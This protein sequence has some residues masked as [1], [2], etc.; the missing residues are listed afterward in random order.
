[1]KPLHFS[2]P[3]ATRLA[4]NKAVQIGAA[5]AVDWLARV[6]T[7]EVAAIR[8]VAEVFGIIMDAPYTVAN[9]VRFCQFED[10]PNSKMS[11]AYLEHHRNRRLSFFLHSRPVAAVYED[12]SVSRSK[13]YPGPLV[14]IDHAI[15]AHAF[16]DEHAAP[17]RGYLWAEF[18]DPALEDADAALMSASFSRYDGPDSPTPPTWKMSVEKMPKVDAVLRLNPAF[19]ARLDIAGSRLILARNRLSLIN[20]AIEGSICLESLLTDEENAEISYRLSLR[21]A[22]LIGTDSTERLEIWNKLKKFY[23]LRSKGVHGSHKSKPD[24]SKTVDDGLSICM[25]VLQKLVELGKIPDWTAFSLQDRTSPVTAS[26]G[27]E[28]QTPDQRKP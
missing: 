20:K 9:G 23:N 26:E 8:Y 11:Q 6:Y 13:N 10:V 27:E 1:M 3:N 2:P 14:T 15:M 5:P 25:R 18:I 7:T 16:A 28:T 17:F 24:D 12:Q 21:A 22:L 4:I 19:L